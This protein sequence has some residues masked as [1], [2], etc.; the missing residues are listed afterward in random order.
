MAIVRQILDKLVRPPMAV[1]NRPWKEPT[2]EMI[3]Q[4]AVELPRILN[5]MSRR[6]RERGIP[7]KVYED[8][9]LTESEMQELEALF[10]SMSSMV[11]EDDK[12]HRKLC[13][14]TNKQ[15][16]FTIALTDRKEFFKL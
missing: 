16:G 3:Q 1:F 6:P 14:L 2:P 12:T 15:Q 13:A 7:M 9:P 5:W 8:R 4:F 11:I 10:G